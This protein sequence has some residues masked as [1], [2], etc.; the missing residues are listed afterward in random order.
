MQKKV[1]LSFSWVSALPF[2]LM[3]AFFSCNGQTPKQQLKQVTQVVKTPE[4]LKVGAQRMELY[5]PKLKGKKV[6]FA[7]NHTSMIGNTH[8]VDTLIASGVNV[9]KIYSPEHGFRGSA[10]A[11][12]TVKSGKDTKTGITIVSL[13]GNNHK[14]KP[15]QLEG[16]DIVVFDIQ[17]VG[18]RFYT[19]IS[20]MSYVMEACAELKIPVIVLDRPNP[21]GHFVDGPVLEKD[22]TSFVGMHQIPVVHGMTI[23]EYAKMVNGEGWLKGGIKC[24]LQVIPV[25]NYT[26]QDLYQLPIKP[27]PNL[28]NMTAI[29]LYPSLCFFEGTIVSVGRG[30]DH[31]FQIMGYPGM[32]SGNFDFTPR[33][34]EGAA[35]SPPYL[36]EKCHGF[37]LR[38]FGDIYIKNLGQLYLY[39][40]INAYKET[41][42]KEGFFNNYF[43]NL[44]G[45]SKLKQQ[46]KDG[47][48][49]EEIRKSWQPE[50]DK[51]KQIRK[52]YL[53]YKDFE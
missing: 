52:K 49:E 7:G 36:G 48:T 23:G 17:D 32:E 20:T 41:K 15:E 38:E 10:D 30:T 21:N 19:Y 14:P 22:F 11:G 33:S 37:D 8:M 26:H 46:I 2:L 18:T 5:L 25:D 39:W 45:N 6:G 40:L 13:Y 9:V 35:K 3:F 31:P 42:D 1:N 28:P 16:V 50:L 34:I 27:S 29:Y 51:F 47:K 4:Q 44:A 24:D 12:E 53:L 43:N